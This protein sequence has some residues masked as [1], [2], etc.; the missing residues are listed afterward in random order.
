ML[1]HDYS[2]NWVGKIQLV[3]NSAYSITNKTLLIGFL[4]RQIFTV[5]LFT[6]KDFSTTV[7]KVGEKANSYQTSNKTTESKGAIHVNLM[8]FLGTK[9][10]VSERQLC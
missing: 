7:F 2:S 10:A 5:V 9:I 8:F 1:A 6:S 3:W 4:F